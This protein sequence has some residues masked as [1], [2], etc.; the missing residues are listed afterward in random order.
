MQNTLTDGL[1]AHFGHKYDDLE[2]SPQEMMLLVAGFAAQWDLKN[3][4]E[5]SPET[6]DLV[7]KAANA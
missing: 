4:G 6:I 3:K 5:I 2:V 7:K 1:R